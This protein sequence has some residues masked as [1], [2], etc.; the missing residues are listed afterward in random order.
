MASHVGVARGLAGVM[1]LNRVG[2]FFLSPAPGPG[3]SLT[4]PLRVGIL[5]PCFTAL[6]GAEILHLEQARLL[7]QQGHRVE[8]VELGRRGDVDAD[9]RLASH[10]IHRVERAGDPGD[11]WGWTDR[12]RYGRRLARA[13]A[14][15]DVVLAGNFPAGP[16]SGHADVRGLTVWYCHEPPRGLYRRATHPQLEA[17]RSTAP[18]LAAV[19]YHERRLRREARLARFP[20]RRFAPAWDQRGVARVDRIWANSAFTRGLVERVYGRTDATVVYPIVPRPGDAP[21]RAGLRRPLRVLTQSRL[22]AVKNVE[23]I[24]RGVAG[25]RTAGLEVELEVVGEG[26][27]RPA[28]EALAAELGLVAPAVRFHGFVEREALDRI[29]ATCEV[30]TLR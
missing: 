20:L 2:P 24:L 3:V 22:A 17:V 26:P 21:R 15:Q 5:H 6:G 8:L 29:A 30:S 14:G 23:I 16:L 28:L 10:Q 13:L 12:L 1:R 27:E 25:A 9:A 19:R 4:A 18:H 11:S 7:A